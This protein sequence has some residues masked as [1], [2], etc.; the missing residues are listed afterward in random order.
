M[1]Q[2]YGD[3][4]YGPETDITRAELLTMLLKANNTPI[5]ET[6]EKCFPDV[7]NNMWYSKYICTAS[8]LDVAHGF[9]D[10]K[11]KPNDPVTT[12][13]AIAFGNKTF[14]T[15]VT[16]SGENWYTAL[17][18]FIDRNNILPTHSY[19]LSTKISRGKAAE[20][21]TRFQE[22]AQKHTPLG[23]KSAGCNISSPIIS[24]EVTLVVNAKERKFNLFVP[25]GYSNSREYSLIIATH[26]RTNSKDQVQKYMGLDK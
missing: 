4:R 14:Q 5:T 11:F 17:Q 22:Y 2:G 12:L 21:I 6:S 26:G 25:N 16:T 13:E 10:G 20:M 18:E 15:G 1:S 23:Y 24:S 8:K 7:D 9:S 3:G 19:T